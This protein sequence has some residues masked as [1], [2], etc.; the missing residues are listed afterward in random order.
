M[1]LKVDG[2]KELLRGWNRDVFGRLEVNKNLA[3]QQ[4]EF[5][6]GVESE[7]SLTEGETEL[8]KEAKDVFK[9]WVLLE[10]THW[11]QLSR[12][13]WL[14][15]GDKN[16]G[17]FHRMA[18]A[19]RRNNSRE[20]IK[21][22][23]RWLEEEQEVREGVVN[24]FQQLLSEEPAWKADIEGLNLQRLNHFE[25]EGLEQPFTEEEIHVAL[26]GMNGDKAP[27][28]EG[29]TV[30]FWQSCWDFVKEEIVDMFKE[31]FDE[32]S[33][34]KSLNSTFLV[35]IPKKGGADDFGDF[36]PISL[37][38]G[39]RQ[40]DPLSPYLFV[41]GMEVLSALLRRAV[42]GG[43]ISGCSLRGR[44]G[45]EMNVSHLLF[46]DDTII[47]CEARQDH[48]TYLSWILAWFEAASG[49]KVGALPSVYLG[50]PLGANHKTTTMWD[51]VE[52]FVLATQRNASIN[53]MWDSSLGQGGWNIRLSRNSN[54]W[55][56]DPLGELFHML[57]D[58][59]ISPKEDSVIW[60]G[61]EHGLFRIRDAY[62]LLT[63][64]NVITF[65]KKSIWVDKVPTKVAFFAWEATWE[66]V[67]TLDRL[68]RWG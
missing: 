47:F 68:Q 23:G 22:N 37:L 41:L 49:C 30:A 50:L 60:K 58:L 33:F 24:A 31:F 27:G 43:F 10:E 54:D 34:A 8:K 38:G 15:E 3:L 62:K 52:L 45:M 66:K 5:W 59:R 29:F 13:L 64:P 4:V 1:W 44:E 21:I 26:M 56:L 2:F 7:R 18:N 20:K 28:P 11:R 36:R 35:L 6:D 46:A 67:L 39:L 14:K 17:F 12:E 40:G 51:G 55:E 9:K 16:I 48:L 63:G 32:K 57:R 25:T 65:P 53:E 19:H 61:G 42:D